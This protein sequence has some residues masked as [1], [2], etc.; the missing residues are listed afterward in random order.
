MILRLGRWV[1][2]FGV[3]VLALTWELSFEFSCDLESFK[4]PNAGTFRGTDPRYSLMYAKLS[5]PKYIREDERKS[6]ITSPANEKRKAEPLHFRSEPQD[7]T[8]LHCNR[9]G[10]LFD[11]DPR[12]ATV[13]NITSKGIRVCKSLTP[14]IRNH[15]G[16]ARTRNPLLAQGLNPFIQS[17]WH[18]RAQAT[19]GLSGQ[20]VKR[21]VRCYLQGSKV[22]QI[23]REH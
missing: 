23:P 18:S 12:F 2:C 9:A 6:Y 20:R 19:Q 7:S 8:T 16:A 15:R 3:L 13:S 4:T 14:V 17:Q 21:I 5:I 11:L 1:E 10:E 22:S